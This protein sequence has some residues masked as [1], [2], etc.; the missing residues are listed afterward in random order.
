M[1]NF[2]MHIQKDCRIR[3]FDALLYDNSSLIALSSRLGCGYSAIKNW[4]SGKRLIPSTYFYKM[5]EMVDDETKKDVKRNS[6]AYPHNWGMILGGVATNERYKATINSRM[7]HVRRFKTA[8]LIAILPDVDDEVWEVLGAC[9]GDGCLTKYFASYDNRVIYETCFTGNR[10]DDFEYY[11]KFLLPMIRAKF[12]F[13]TGFCFRP[14]YNVISVKIRSKRLFTFLNELGMPIGRK[15]DKLRIPEVVFESSKTCRAAM[16]RGLLDT[17]G[18]I[19]ARKDEAYKYPHLEITSASKDFRDDIKR[20]IRSF[21]LPAYI[22]TENVLIRGGK[23]LKLW[24]QEIGSSH[25]THIKRYEQWL[26]KGLLL[27]KGS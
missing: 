15:K 2:R 19:F 26:T 16:L 5:L 8:S 22:R 1:K 23:N 24:M 25:P 20:L 13:N 27:P 4:K 18:H 17:D 7:E 10:V 6:R 11:N 9:M 21:N 3:F 12:G 14:K